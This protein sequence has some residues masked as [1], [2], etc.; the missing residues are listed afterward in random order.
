M[1]P[2]AGTDE[3]ALISILCKR[4]N[5]QRQEIKTRFKTVLGRDLAK[6]IKSETSGDFRDTLLALLETPLDYDV[7]QLREAVDVCARL[8]SR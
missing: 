7:R 1:H 4:T 8:P 6:D 2:R 5:A 3:Q